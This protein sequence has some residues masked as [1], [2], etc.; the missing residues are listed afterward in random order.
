MPTEFRTHARIGAE[1]VYLI[2]AA[3]SGTVAVVLWLLDVGGRGVFAILAGIFAAT[4]V[5]YL[6][7]SEGARVRAAQRRA[8]HHPLGLDEDS[9][10][11]AR[12]ISMR[13]VRSE[14]ERG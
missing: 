7:R 3:I 1:I 13:L 6:V 12:R 9:I 5:G 8:D 14:G 2:V 4:F 11:A 10:D